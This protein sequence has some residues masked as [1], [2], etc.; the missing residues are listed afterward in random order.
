MIIEKLKTSRSPA[1][2]SDLELHKYAVNERC[3]LITPTTIINSKN[4][5]DLP[6]TTNKKSLHSKS[7]TDVKEFNWKWLQDETDCK[8]KCSKCVPLLSSVLFVNCK[9]LKFNFCI[10]YEIAHQVRLR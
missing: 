2:A 3:F 6:R 4:V 8:S 9:K 10:L 5:A 7:T 1:F